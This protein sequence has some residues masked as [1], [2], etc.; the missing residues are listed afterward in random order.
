MFRL[1]WYPSRKNLMLSREY[2]VRNPPTSEELYFSKA[3]WLLHI[4]LP[5]TTEEGAMATQNLKDWGGFFLGG[6]GKWVGWLHN[7]ILKMLRNTKL[8]RNYLEFRR[9]YLEFR[10]IFAKIMKHFCG[11]LQHQLNIF[12][13]FDRVGRSVSG[14][15][16]IWSNSYPVQVFFLPDLDPNLN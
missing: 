10:E 8:W 13:L 1:N 15:I 14:L 5:P 9:N 2:H 3:V 12:E 4:N 16:R 6:G 11:N 7:N